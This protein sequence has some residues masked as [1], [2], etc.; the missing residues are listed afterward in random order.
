MEQAF[1]KPYPSMERKCTTM[2]EIEKN[3][4]IPQ[5]KKLIWVH[6]DI[7]RDSENKLLYHKFST[8][9]TYNKKNTILGCIPR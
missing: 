8:K 3:Y 4:K 6:Q 1:N 2:K 7:G 9:I 5:N